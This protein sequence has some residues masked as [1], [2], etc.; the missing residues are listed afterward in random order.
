MC[1]IGVAARGLLKTARDVAIAALQASRP[2]RPK[3]SPAEA[4]ELARLTAEVERL[5]ATIYLTKR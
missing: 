5:S 1:E 4:T 2:G 3:Q